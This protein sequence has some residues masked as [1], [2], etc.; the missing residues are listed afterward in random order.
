MT[1]GVED[2]GE[3]LSGEPTCS[4]SWDLVAK[5]RKFWV[6]DVRMGKNGVDAHQFVQLLFFDTEQEFSSES[7]WLN[8]W[9]VLFDHIIC[10]RYLVY[11][12]YQQSL[13]VSTSSKVQC[14]AS[15]SSSIFDDLYS[16]RI[17]I[18]N[19]R[20]LAARKIL[21]SLSE[22]A[23]V[24]MLLY[25]DNSLIEQYV[26]T[27]DE[28]AANEFWHRVVSKRKSFRRL[29]KLLVGHEG[30]FTFS[31]LADRNGD[32]LAML[33]QLIHPS[34]IS[35]AF[36]WLPPINSDSLDGWIPFR[37]PLDASVRTIKHVVCVVLQSLAVMD[38]YP[39]GG[40]D[41]LASPVFDLRNPLHVST[42]MAKIAML[43]YLRMVLLDTNEFFQVDQSEG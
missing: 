38:E 40:D 42:R 32:E 12:C 10:Y 33:G 37:Y 22:Y 31:V 30:K 7:D 11:S 3:F 1:I 5:L 17:L 14:F 6:E 15:L 24:E 29:E 2:D 26:S 8:R 13:D 35:T 34:Y 19:G 4:L 43:S 20:E 16:I 39:F 41:H 27:H 9:V 21:R 36:T 25:Q 23:E 28:K 18:A